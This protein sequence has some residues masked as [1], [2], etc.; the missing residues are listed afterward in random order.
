MEVLRPLLLQLIVSGSVEVLIASAS[1][2][3]NHNLVLTRFTHVQ[4]I[5]NL[6]LDGLRPRH[7]M[8]PLNNHYLK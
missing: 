2:L 5:R 3:F 6:I 7:V 4:A 8:R 1:I